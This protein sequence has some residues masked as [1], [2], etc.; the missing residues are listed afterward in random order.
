[1]NSGN[2]HTSWRTSTWIV[3]LGIAI[4]VSPTNRSVWGDDPQAF[5]VFDPAPSADMRGHRSDGGIRNRTTA[6]DVALLEATRTQVVEQGKSTLL[7]N[8]F[9]D[10]EFEAVFNRSTPTATG[11][12]LSGRVAAHEASA[13]TLVVNGDVLAGTVWAPSGTYRITG[14][15]EHI[16]I[17]KLGSGM[18]CHL[19][20]PPGRGPFRPAGDR[21]RV[22]PSWAD[23]ST[24]EK[25]DAEEE[26]V[27][28]LLVVYPSSARR[29][30]GGHRSIRA[31]IDHDVAAVNDAF[32]ASAARQR[33]ELSAAVEM[34]YRH[35]G[36]FT[37]LD[38]LV[39]GSDLREAVD[40]LLASYQA[41]LV[42]LHLGSAPDG[43][44]GVAGAAYS[45]LDPTPDEIARYGYTV[46]YSSAFAHEL[47][48]IMGLKHERA[49]NNINKPF[50]YSHGY[51]FPDPMDSETT[52]CTTMGAK[53]PCLPRFSNPEQRYPDEDGVPL[54][55]PG[56]EPT[57]DADGPA[58]AVRHL[59]EL[60]H[61]VADVRPRDEACAFVLSPAP[62]EVPA[63][64]GSYTV[65]V[66]TAAECEWSVRSLD[67][68][69]TVTGPTN[70]IGN[71]QVAFEVAANP[72]WQRELGLAVAGEVHVLR[73]AAAREITAVCNR[74]PA[75]VAAIERKVGKGCNEINADDL[76]RIDRLRIGPRDITARAGDFDGMSGLG[77]LEIWTYWA[78]PYDGPAIDIGRS[79]FA[80][81]ANLAVLRLSAVD[82]VLAQGAFRDLESLETLSI[83]DAVDSF[84]DGA[85]AGLERLDWLIL[86]ANRIE[87]MSHG[88]FEGL[89]NLR[90]LT[91][92]YNDGLKTLEPGVFSFLTALER[93]DLGQNALETLPLGVFGGLTKL[94]HLA[95]FGNRLRE[96]EVGLFDGLQALE[97]LW[98]DDNLLT[99]LK[100]GVFRDLPRVD[101]ILLR[102]N[103]LTRLGSGV[104]DGLDNLAEL[105]L[106]HNRL[107]ELEEGIFEHCCQRLWKLLLDYNELT[108]LPPDIHRLPALRLLDVRYNRLQDV[109]A[110]DFSTV[111]DAKLEQ[112]T[113][114]R[115]LI[116][117]FARAD[118]P[119][120]QSFLRVVNYFPTGGDVEITAIDDAGTRFG[121][122][123]LEV[124]ALGARHV[125][126]DDLEAGNLSKG[127]SAG[128]GPGTGEWRLEIETDLDAESLAYVRTGD[129]F[130]TSTH[131][132]V[133][134]AGR[135]HAVALFNPAGED[136][137]ASRLRVMN[138]GDEEATVRVTA[139]DDAGNAGDGTVTFSLPAQGARSFG[140][141]ELESGGTGFEGSFGDPTGKWRLQVESDR[142][143]TVVNLLESPEGYLSNLST[144][145]GPGEDGVFVVPLFP[146]A[147]DQFEGLVR[148]VNDDDVEGTVRIEAS[149]QSSW[150]YDAVELEIGANGAVNFDSDDLELGN[151]D[152]G[153]ST[154]TGAG[155]GDWRLELG[156]DLSLR[157]SAYV[158]TADGFLSPMHDLAPRMVGPYHRL[159]PPEDFGYRVVTLNPGRNTNQVGFLRFANPGSEVVRLT[160][161]VYDDAGELRNP[162]RSIRYLEPGATRVVT[163][164][165]LE[166]FWFVGRHGVG[167]WQIQID[168]QRSIEVMSLLRAPTGHLVNLSSGTLE[169]REDVGHATEDPGAAPR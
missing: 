47:G 17:R 53:L 122:L 129:G 120:R 140:A 63:A 32:S 57:P 61:L 33:I 31:L 11:F 166:E 155:Q 72:D 89:E 132:L 21:A 35:K 16:V 79:M 50:P 59:N 131:D 137:Q 148:V 128:T 64:G 164:A 92:R 82:A 152:K 14:T 46:G 26:V 49:D 110:E 78:Y 58:D 144:V 18:R 38:D 27:T 19:A 60:R 88:V 68:A 125:N 101:T 93:L 1:M 81:L 111:R 43:L 13:V 105:I 24:D 41:D 104:F 130:V 157:V 138:M 142:D 168:A 113:R 45:F 73:Q 112:R 160:Y 83:S 86:N 95:L 91:M 51:L 150:E 44:I 114:T 66:E 2:R 62:E 97:F 103:R 5:A 8:L 121:P 71:V 153:L 65:A 126:S 151:A 52:L 74:S 77:H 70:G 134:A 141:S 80:G 165:E 106:R 108:A 102:G 75:A 87:G 139:I 98:L 136:I 107:E 158:R 123:T 4:W 34:D 124:E 3:V 69:V 56:D 12:A 84:P 22:A 10:I 55:V 29:L 145:A 161:R 37:A 23:A 163:S 42:Y 25:D 7:L 162:V 115:T 169:T 54:G 135:E 85:F 40:E 119:F 118:D 167:K 15:S 109:S 28:D 9:A 90:E 94:E 149:D 36:I 159:F 99:E 48:H 116:P 143:T 117:L 39:K 96:L 6:A 76:A 133:S 146:A 154:G 67:R 20:A 30:E 100:P 127:L 156:S 147:G